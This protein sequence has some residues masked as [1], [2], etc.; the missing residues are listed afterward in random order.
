MRTRKRIKLTILVCYLI[1]I[2]SCAYDGQNKDQIETQTVQ[3]VGEE[4]LEMGRNDNDQESH[5][6][7]EVTP[8]VEET[9][10]IE[11]TTAKEDTSTIESTSAI[12]TAPTLQFKRAESE[13]LAGMLQD[14]AGAQVC[15]VVAGEIFGSGV[16]YEIDDE[17]LYIATAGHVLE[18]L[19]G[20]VYVRFQND[21][22]V[23]SLN[24]WKSDDMDV[25]F[26]R[27]PLK[28]VKEFEDELLLA[29][30][31]EEWFNACK[32][33]SGVIA[34]GAFSSA[35]GEAYEGKMEDPFLYVE[36]YGHYMMVANVF[37]A[38]GMSGGGLYDEEGHFLGIICGTNEEQ[39]T[40]AIPDGEVQIAFSKMQ[41]LY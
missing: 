21:I 4:P 33:G 15:R 3:V 17:F 36:Q 39:M 13:N 8:I 1:F 14:D 40:A 26:I 22:S 32:Q 31:G 34:M 18:Q 6:Q 2:Q 5:K 7:I 37:C 10:I 11:S 41:S 24:Y 27:I 35:V 9:S 30:R 25:G 29:V 12:E 16:L 19:T 38:P 28:D 23:S 20:A